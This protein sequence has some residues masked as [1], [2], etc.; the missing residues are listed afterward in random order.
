[1]DSYGEF[2]LFRRIR[3]PAKPVY[4][5]DLTAGLLL[6]AV[7]LAIVIFVVWFN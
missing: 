4:A 5:I 2:A 6:L 3:K 1:M 7:L